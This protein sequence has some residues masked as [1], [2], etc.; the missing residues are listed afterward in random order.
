MHSKA[1]TMWTLAFLIMVMIISVIVLGIIVLLQSFTQK[2][3]SKGQEDE[4]LKI[5]DKAKE[6][7]GRPG[8]EVVYFEVKKECV[9]YVTYDGNLKVKYKTVKDPVEYQTGFPWNGFEQLEQRQLKPGNYF[10]RVLAD[11][12][13]LMGGASDSNSQ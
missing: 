13:E 4:I 5:M 2:S 6:I 7:R 12:V 10:F 3:C 8:Y 1:L 11:R 9:D